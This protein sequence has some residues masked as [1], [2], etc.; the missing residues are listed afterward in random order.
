MLLRG[1]YFKPLK[2][3]AVGVDN[4][5]KTIRRRMSEVIAG[6]AWSGRYGAAGTF[7]RATLRDLRP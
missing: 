1:L 5:D 4:R 7:T 6:V 3:S 2:W